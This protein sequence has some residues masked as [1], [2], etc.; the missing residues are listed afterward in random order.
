MLRLGA[1]LLM[2]LTVSLLAYRLGPVHSHR[3]GRVMPHDLRSR[4]YFEVIDHVQTARLRDEAVLALPEDQRNDTHACEEARRSVQAVVYRFPPGTLLVER[5]RPINET[6]F[7]LLKTEMGAYL[8]SL[9]MADHLRRCLALFLVF[10]LLAAIVVLYV[11]RFQRVLAESLPKLVGVCALVLTTI[12]L[13]LLL[14]RFS[15]MAVVVPLTMTAL[16]FTIAYN[17]QFALLMSLSLTLAL[18]V[19]VGGSLNDL[20]VAMGGQAAAIL[21]L[22]HVRT[23]TRLVEVGCLA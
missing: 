8:S 14:S 20:L 23:R 17:P 9:G 19:T 22:Q 7:H 13:A 10:T 5:G 21:S 1:V 12:L 4:V 6:H 11:V 15:T 18:V 16:I 3:L 2:S